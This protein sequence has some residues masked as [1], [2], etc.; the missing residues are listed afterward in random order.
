MKTAPLK[1]FFYVYMNRRA[2][3]VRMLRRS[4]YKNQSVMLL[5]IR[6]EH[7]AVI[8]TFQFLQL[9]PRNKRYDFPDRETAEAFFEKTLKRIVRKRTAA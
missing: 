1:R 6:E 9:F 2:T 7:F 3:G 4:E 8:C 5:Q